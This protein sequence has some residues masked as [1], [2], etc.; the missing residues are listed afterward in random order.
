MS[1]GSRSRSLS[2]ASL[3]GRDA[4]ARVGDLDPQAAAEQGLA[5]D[6][7]RVDGAENSVALSSNSASR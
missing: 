2:T 4:E 1:P 5:G 7:D 3:L 6:H